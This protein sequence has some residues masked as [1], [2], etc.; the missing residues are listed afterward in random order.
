MLFTYNVL[1]VETIVATGICLPNIIEESDVAAVFRGEKEGV[2]F[3]ITWLTDPE[4]SCISTSTISSGFEVSWDLDE[5]ASAGGVGDVGLETMTNESLSRSESTIGLSTSISLLRRGRL[6]ST[7]LGDRRGECR[8]WSDVR[9]LGA[10]STR[11][12]SVSLEESVPTSSSSS[13]LDVTSA[14]LANSIVG[15]TDAV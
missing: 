7:E 15:V 13:S 5:L 9:I 10:S 8:D 2:A 1:L 11:V 12:A 14:S 6:P 3:G 4:A